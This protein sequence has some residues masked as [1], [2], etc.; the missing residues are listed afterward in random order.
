VD[1][2]GSESSEVVLLRKRGRARRDYDVNLTHYYHE[3]DAK[4]RD[5][6]I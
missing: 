1:G 6:V 4:T 3:R 2:Q 5:I